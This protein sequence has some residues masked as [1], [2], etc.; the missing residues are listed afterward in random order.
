MITLSSADFV[1]ALARADVSQ[2]AFARLTGI[3]T[4][5]VNNWC[6]GRADVPAWAI[7]LAIVLQEHSPE[8]LAIMAEELSRNAPHDITTIPPGLNGE[9]EP[10]PLK[11][12]INRPRRSAAPQLPGSR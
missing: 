11:P 9:P 4:R 5:Q 7:L 8:A 1:A 10:W 3:S 12:R 6:R 2:A